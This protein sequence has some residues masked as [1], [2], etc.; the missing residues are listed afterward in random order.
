[1][2][3]IQLLGDSSVEKWKYF[4][5]WY[6]F[7]GTWIYNTALH[8]IGV[9]FGFLVRLVYTGI[10]DVKTNRFE[11]TSS[12]VFSPRMDDRKLLP[13]RYYF[14]CGCHVREILFKVK[15]KRFKSY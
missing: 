1:M 12:D 13:I 10:H 11:T 8:L 5:S 6:Y 3:E 7:D 9:I 4:F 15:Q 2:G 14:F